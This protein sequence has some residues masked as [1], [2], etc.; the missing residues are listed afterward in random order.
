MESTY[1]TSL[2]AEFF[3]DDSEASFEEDVA[4]EMALQVAAGHSASTFAAPRVFQYESLTFDSDYDF[5]D[6]LQSM[7]DQDARADMSS[8]DN[9]RR[10]AKGASRELDMIPED[11]DSKKIRSARAA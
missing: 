9:S 7:I 10:S 4:Q 5:E 11:S 8:M 6:E 3:D 2:Q 1:R